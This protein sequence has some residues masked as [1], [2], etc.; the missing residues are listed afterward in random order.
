MADTAPPV[1]ADRDHP[2]VRTCPGLRDVGLSDLDLDGYFALGEAEGVE[3]EDLEAEYIPL[4]KR[5]LELKLAR[6]EDGEL[7]INAPE[8]FWASRDEPPELLETIQSPYQ[9]IKLYRQLEDY[10]LTLNDCIQYHS[11]EIA[12]SHELMVGI[13]L[14]LA[15]Q[16]KSVIILGGGDGYAVAE[17]LRHPSVERVRLVE[18]DPKMIELHSEHPPLLELNRRALLDPRVEVIVGDAL[19]HF[20]NLDETFDVVIDDCEFLVTG[21][22][23]DTVDYYLSYYEALASKLSPGGVGSVMEPIEPE[24]LTGRALFLPR[25]I[26]RRQELPQRTA[27]TIR[28]QIKQ[29]MSL[30]WPYTTFVEF[31]CLSLGLEMYTY[32]SRSQFPK[33]RRPAPEGS[34]VLQSVLDQLDRSH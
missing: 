32:F 20:L 8:E 29:M 4:A 31:Q 1:P 5:L 23:D 27:D 19:G 2:L 12:H 13:P 28:G 9:T 21:Q 14:C 25:I 24:F 6:L 3:V 30:L 34:V 11:Q 18:L 17:A 16:A 22:S 33:A 26:S 7:E 10:F 15:E